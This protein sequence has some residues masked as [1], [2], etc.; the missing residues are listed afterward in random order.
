MEYKLKARLA[1]ESI[2]GFI[3]WVHILPTPQIYLRASEHLFQRGVC[4]LE[5]IMVFTSCCFHGASAPD[6]LHL[7]PVSSDL[8]HL[9]ATAGHCIRASEGSIL[10]RPSRSF[11]IRRRITSFSQHVTNSSPTQVSSCDDVMS[12]TDM[13]LPLQALIF[14]NQNEVVRSVQKSAM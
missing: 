4:H 7:L 14:W 12:P 13:S 3:L 6:V 1:A 8:C 2:Q 9:V 10:Q 11:S 5:T